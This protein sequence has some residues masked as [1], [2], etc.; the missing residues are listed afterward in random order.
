[1][2]TS[3]IIASHLET[4]EREL[5]TPTARASDRVAQLLADDF[6]E[7]GSS[8][9]SY[10]KASIIAALRDES[11]TAITATDF[12]V[13]LLA[14]EV[15]LVTYRSCLQAQPDVHALRSSIWRRD[16]DAWRMVFHQGTLA[17]APA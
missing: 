2:Q 5:L 12:A 11:P 3:A 1:M 9:R 17:A 14:P 4:L 15:A 7:F 16:G 10:D 6:V 8:G 13:R